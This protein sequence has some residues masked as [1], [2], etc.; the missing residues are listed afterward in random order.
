L[1]KFE[2]Y[3]EKEDIDKILEGINKIFQNKKSTTEDFDLAFAVLDRYLTTIKTKRWILSKEIIEILRTAF[4]AGHELPWLVRQKL[5]LELG[6]IVEKFPGE[7]INQIELVDVIVGIMKDRINTDNDPD[8]KFN[9]VKVLGKI[10][11]EFPD[12]VIPSLNSYMKHYERN[13]R[14]N[15]II[16]LKNIAKKFDKT[17]VKQILPFFTEIYEKD[18]EHGYI[19]KLISESIKEITEQMHSDE[20]FGDFMLTKQVLCPN[21]NDFF[22]EGL[23]VCSHCGK[24]LPKCII[25][26]EKVELNQAHDLY[27]CKQCGL[28]FHQEPCLAEWHTKNNNCPHCLSR[29]ELD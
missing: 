9:A 21:C 4:I 20:V 17:H 19:T 25:C 10:G 26:G 28:W 6:S 13:I 29:L 22:P 8:N 1:Q 16:A 18:T 12:R 23:G 27:Q 24:P 5:I 14:V 2:K 7:L 15:A 3:F 11:L